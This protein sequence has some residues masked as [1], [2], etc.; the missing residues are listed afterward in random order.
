MST[1]TDRCWCPKC[2]RNVLAISQGPNHLVHGIIT[3]LF[4]PWAIVWRHVSTRPR[5]WWCPVCTTET[6]PNKKEVVPVDDEKVAFWAALATWAVI[7]GL[8]A[9]VCCLFSE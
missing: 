4:L 9:L 6:L 3:I 7:L 5:P 2:K 1:K 8:I